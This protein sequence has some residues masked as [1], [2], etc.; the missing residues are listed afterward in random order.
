MS[1]RIEVVRKLGDRW[2]AEL[3]VGAS[4]VIVLG[5]S[6]ARIPESSL[7]KG[8]QATVV[9]IVQRPYPTAT[10]RRYVVLPR[11]PSDLRVA[12]TAAGG[13]GARG[14]PAGAHGGG[15]GSIA[16]GATATHASASGAALTATPDA[17][18][19]DL[20]GLVGTTVRVGGLVT[21]LQPGGFRLDDGTAIGTVVL[22]AAAADL[23][24]LIESGDAV[25]VAGRVEFERIGPDRG[26]RGSGDGQPRRRSDGGQP[27]RRCPVDG[28]RG[29]GSGRGTDHRSS[30]G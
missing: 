9:G 7:L 17:D 1:G 2:R 6:G 4:R 3:S 23:L 18:L 21:D 13:P 22:R 27:R 15:P 24:P 26:G 16:G 19:S 30:R 25:N 10:D 28:S 5:R 8:H 20:A 11:Q 29:S 14:G 12:P